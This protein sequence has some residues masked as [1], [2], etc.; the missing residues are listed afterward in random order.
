MTSKL[1]VVIADDE[2]PARTFLAAMLRAF[3]DV[4]IVAEAE[5]GTEAVEAIERERPDLALLDLQMPELDGLGVVRLLRKSRTPLIAFVTAYDEYAVRAFELNAVD[6]LLKPVDRAR[7]RETLNRAHERLESSERRQS[8]VAHA[9]NAAA[10]YIQSQ[11]PQY[12]KRI[13]VRRNNEIT[14]LPVSQIASVVAEA[15]LLHIM[16]VANERH[17]I[18]YRLRDLETKLDP[19]RFLRLGRGALV[20]IDMVV[21]ALPM[22]GGTYIV[23]LRNGQELKVSRLQSRILK[24]QLLRL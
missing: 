19:A 6:Y 9:R 5:T 24:E 7:L 11:G 15:E 17:T 16:T 10:D 13:P 2:R 3:E 22:V 18:N 14:I 20:N 23:Q 4:D 8:E 1:R 21:K 12:L